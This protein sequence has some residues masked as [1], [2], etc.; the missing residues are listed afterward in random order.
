[1]DKFKFLR[2][3]VGYSLAYLSYKISFYTLRKLFNMVDE[4]IDIDTDTSNNNNVLTDGTKDR[5]TTH[6]YETYKEIV[7]IISVRG[8]QNGLLHYLVYV[9]CEWEQRILL[10][11][12][13]SLTTS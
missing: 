6:D 10:Y 12:S 5:I 2:S 11:V 1:M 13:Y 3:Y 9:V 8:G 4:I 7:N